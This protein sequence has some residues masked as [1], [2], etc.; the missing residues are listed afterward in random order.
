MQPRLKAET[1]VSL[2]LRWEKVDDISV[3]VDVVGWGGGAVQFRPGLV[4][5]GKC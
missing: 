5:R 2:I 1:V 4:G 3:V